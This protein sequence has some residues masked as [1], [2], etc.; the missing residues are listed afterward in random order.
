M[1]GSIV[2]PEMDG[3]A[4]KM[5]AHLVTT[6]PQLRR[7]AQPVADVFLDHAME[8]AVEDW[9]GKVTRPERPLS[10]VDEAED[11]FC[12]NLTRPGRQPSFTGAATTAACG[13]A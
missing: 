10:L 4:A 7:Y 6:I 3:N 12:Q 5:W 9:R 13:A 2:V 11:A 8:R 1:P